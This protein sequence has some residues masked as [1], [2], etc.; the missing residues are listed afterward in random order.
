MSNKGIVVT[1]TVDRRSDENMWLRKVVDSVVTIAKNGD[2]A[3]AAMHLFELGFNVYQAARILKIGERSQVTAEDAALWKRVAEANIEENVRLRERCNPSK[4][5]MIG[6][7]GHYVSE[8]VRAEIE[9][10]RKALKPFATIDL[11]E[12]HMPTDF[13]MYVLHARGALMPNAG[14]NKPSA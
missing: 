11:L 6:D 3:N 10:L 12:R 5:V 9:N 13:A 2:K 7:V 4:V 8:A 1:E 14:S